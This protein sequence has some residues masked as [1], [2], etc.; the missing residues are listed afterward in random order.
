[1]PRYGIQLADYSRW[2]SG[3]YIQRNLENYLAGQVQASALGWAETLQFT[4]AV[5]TR[6]P[7]ILMGALTPQSDIYTWVL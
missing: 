1:M 7:L 3:Q 6:S 4:L 2:G 5:L